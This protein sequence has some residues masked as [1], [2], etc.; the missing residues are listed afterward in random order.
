MPT[1][2]ALSFWAD[3]FVTKAEDVESEDNSDDE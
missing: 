3:G 2:F 1:T